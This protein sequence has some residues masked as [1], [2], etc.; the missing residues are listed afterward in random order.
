VTKPG[1]IGAAKILDVRAGKR[2]KLTDR[3]L[4]LGSSRLRKRC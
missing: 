1:F 3:C 4:R 2:P